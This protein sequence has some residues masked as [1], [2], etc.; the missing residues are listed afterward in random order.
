MLKASEPQNR[1]RRGSE[2]DDCPV[3]AVVMLRDWLRDC[4][5]ED[6][7]NALMERGAASRTPNRSL[8]C[9]LAMAGCVDKKVFPDLAL[10]IFDRMAWFAQ[11]VQMPYGLDQASSRSATGLARR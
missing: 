4:K 5:T 10:A 8:G 1:M 7:M 2:G 6:G 9:M 11:N 3:V